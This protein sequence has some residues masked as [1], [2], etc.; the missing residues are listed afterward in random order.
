MFHGDVNL[1]CTMT[2]LS[3]LSSFA[4]T[5]LWVFLLGRPMIGKTIPIPYAN[6]AISLGSFTI[7]LILGVGFKHKWPKKAATLSAR[8]SRPF[9]FLVLLILPV[10]GTYHNLHF[11]YL[12]SWRHLVSG[13]AL[14]F[15]G[16]ILGAT[17][18]AL[19]RQSRPQII[20]ISLETAIQ[21]AAIGFVILN[22]TFESPYSDMGVIPV[23]S[24][25][26]FSTG[27]IM[28]VVYAGY[29]LIQQ[30]RQGCGFTP[31]AQE[32]KEPGNGV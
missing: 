19:A 31:V 8:V 9:F 16:Y 13:I 24:F 29:L 25:L 32:D 23:L 17:L 5:S 10:A 4:F 21:N 7:P 12:C 14:G 2:F 3:T 22:L 1:S 27:P 15:S 20:A 28:F 18:A 30:F 6:I 11:F 26:F